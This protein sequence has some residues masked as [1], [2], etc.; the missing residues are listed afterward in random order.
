[1]RKL[2]I[3]TGCL[4]LLTASALALAGMALPRAASSSLPAVESRRSETFSIDPAHS[5]V[6]FKVKH[7][8]IA[9]VYGRFND[10]TGEVVWDSDDPHGHSI[11]AEVKAASVDTNA[12]GRDEHLRGPDFFDTANFPAIIFASNAVKESG[13]DKYEVQGT[14]TLHGVEKPITVI[15]E[16]TG[17]ENLPRMGKRLGLAC[18]FTVKRSEFGMTYGIDGAVSD[19]VTIMLGFECGK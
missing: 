8:G 4:A 12:K 3:R 10:V 19:E 14:L 15:V 1:M 9:Y 17:L 7:M 6:V 2:M 16:K 18:E 5:S 13:T 11:K